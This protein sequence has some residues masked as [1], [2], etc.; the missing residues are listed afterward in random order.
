MVTVSW[1]TST[2]QPRLRS[3]SAI[4]GTSRISGQ[5]VM[6]VVPSASSAAAISFS[7]LFFAPTTSTAPTRRA[8]PVTAKCS[9][10]PATLSGARPGGAGGHRRLPSGQDAVHHGV[11]LLAGG[12]VAGLQRQPELHRHDVRGQRGGVGARRHVPLGLPALE[13]LPDGRRA[14]PT[15]LREEV[16]DPLGARG[17]GGGREHDHAAL[18]L[19]RRG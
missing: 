11:E 7:T 3:T 18:R 2:V 9:A 4:S 16:A 14:R 13:P 10:T 17:V 15:L 5:L 19:V 6:V 12:P 1:S 8:P